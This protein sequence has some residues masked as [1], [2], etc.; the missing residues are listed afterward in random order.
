MPQR[1]ASPVN[2]RELFGRVIDRTAVNDLDVQPRQ[3][4]R[5]PCCVVFNS[6]IR[7]V[8]SPWSLLFQQLGF[9]RSQPHRLTARSPAASVYFKN[10]VAAG[11]TFVAAADSGKMPCRDV[12]PIAAN[13]DRVTSARDLANQTPTDGR[14]GI[15]SQARSDVP[16][17]IDT[18]VPRR[19]LITSTRASSCLASAATMIVP[20]PGRG[21][22]NPIGLSGVPTP[23]SGSEHTHRA[24]QAPQEP[25]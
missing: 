19:P 10:T 4:R 1:T 5:G 2:F 15:A 14:N 3:T 12:I 24:S 23:L 18:V 8:S 7:Q 6:L 9:R 17:V 25:A 11:A 13:E 16:W 20:S 22:S 21:L